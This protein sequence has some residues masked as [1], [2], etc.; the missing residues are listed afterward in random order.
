VR[1]VLYAW[2]ARGGRGKSPRVALASGEQ[3]GSRKWKDTTIIILPL[4]H[5]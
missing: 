2:T 3:V 1:A 5:P 4:I